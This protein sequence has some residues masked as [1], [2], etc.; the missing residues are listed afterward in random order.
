MVA[1]ISLNTLLPF[2][3][4]FSPQHSS[5]DTLYGYLLVHRLSLQSHSKQ[6]RGRDHVHRIHSCILSIFQEYS[7]LVM[8]AC[9]IN[10]RMNE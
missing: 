4:H 8:K 9:F 2:P 5:A 7:G 6:H 1:L 10:E 3:F